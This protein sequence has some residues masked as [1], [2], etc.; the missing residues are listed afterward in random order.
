MH[1]AAALGVSSLEGCN[2]CA[3]GVCACVQASKEIGR[4]IVHEFTR[5][6]LIEAGAAHVVPPFSVVA[7]NTMDLSVGR[8]DSLLTIHCLLSLRLYSA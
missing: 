7:S 6:A 8:S 2:A 5:E 4:P 3:S 1:A